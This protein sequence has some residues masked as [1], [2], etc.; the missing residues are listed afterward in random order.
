MSSRTVLITGAAGG[1]GRSAAERMALLGWQVFAADL[2]EE[3]LAA[4]G[5]NPNITPVH[6]DVTD[7]GSVKRMCDEIIDQV[8]HLD[9]VVNF[10]GVI[11]VGSVIEVDEATLKRVIDINLFGTYRVNKAVFGLVKVCKGRI[12]NISSETGWQTAAPFNGPYAM[13]K[14]ALEAYTDSLRREVCLFDVKVIKVQPGPFRTQ[15]TG[16]V[17][18]AFERA[19]NA[20]IYFG[21]V[22]RKMAPMVAKA[23]SGGSDPSVLSRVIEQALTTRHPKST[24]SVRPGRDRVFLEKLPVSWA[25]RIYKKVLQS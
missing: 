2:D 15:M 4:L 8:D 21:D 11:G 6:V 7:A 25:D 10:A 16:G 22:L 18:S 23:T 20:S 13:S 17:V 14:H 19:A 12:I 24:Y 3:A 5:E 1:L 9:G